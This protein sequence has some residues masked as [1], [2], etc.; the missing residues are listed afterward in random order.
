M[1]EMSSDIDYWDTIDAEAVNI[2]A[3]LVLMEER[4]L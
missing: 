2:R 4:D 3:G 1:R